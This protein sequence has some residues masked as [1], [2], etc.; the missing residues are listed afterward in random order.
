MECQS[1]GR[2]VST[3]LFAVDNNFLLEAIRPAGELDSFLQ[4]PVSA[5]VLEEAEDAET[6]PV[7]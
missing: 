5:P 7:A 1:Y 3:Q 4:G 6:P 2:S